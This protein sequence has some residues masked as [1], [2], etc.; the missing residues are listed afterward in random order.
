M[1]PIWAPVVVILLHLVR[2]TVIR[3]LWQLWGRPPFWG[4]SR[5]TGWTLVCQPSSPSSS[6]LPL[7][8]FSGL[9]VVVADSKGVLRKWF[10][11]RFGF[12]LQDRRCIQLVDVVCPVANLKFVSRRNT[13]LCKLLLVKPECWDEPFKGMPHH[14][15]EEGGC[16]QAGQLARSWPEIS[17]G[18]R[19]EFKL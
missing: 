11:F 1:Q 9:F 18:L 3:F 19:F 2:K 16:D 8:E 12:Y 10:Y 15:E 13:T 5:R 7:W 4:G 17:C 14:H 6:P